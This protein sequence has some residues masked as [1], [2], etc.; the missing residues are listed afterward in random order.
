VKIP[1]C[2]ITT[3]KEIALK[4]IPWVP[5]LDSRGRDALDFHDIGVTT[6]R[7]LIDEAY[8]RGYRDGHADRIIETT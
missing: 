4:I 8:R 1:S 6:L 5:T 3:E 2:P 7:V